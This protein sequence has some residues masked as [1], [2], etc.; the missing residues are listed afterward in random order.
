MVLASSRFAALIELRAFMAS[1]RDELF[2]A[3]LLTR[4]APPSLNEMIEI[5]RS[6][7]NAMHLNRVTPNNAE[8]K[9]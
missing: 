8:H 5:S 6:M 3:R 4:N 1:K 9:I 7:N 2:C